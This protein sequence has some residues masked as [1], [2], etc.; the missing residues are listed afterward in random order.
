MEECAL[1]LVCLTA[2]WPCLSFLIFKVGLM[3][4][5]VTGIL[6]VTGTSLSAVPGT[7]QVGQELVSFL[8]GPSEESLAFS[9]PWCPCWEAGVRASIRRWW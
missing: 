9:E 6:E 5:L 3:I 8:S 7:W 1:G 4:L 2:S